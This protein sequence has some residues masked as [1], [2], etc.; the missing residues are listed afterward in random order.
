VSVARRSSNDDRVPFVVR[1]RPLEIIKDRPFISFWSPKMLNRK[2]R[3]RVFEKVRNGYGG[4]GV[5]AE[6]VP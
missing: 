6:M 1:Q 2:L 4:G 3:F 5:I